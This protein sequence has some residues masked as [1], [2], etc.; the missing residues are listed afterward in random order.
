MEP[1]SPPWMY[2]NLGK[3]HTGWEGRNQEAKPFT[4]GHPEGPWVKS[5]L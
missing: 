5:P 1:L 4:Q 3:A 2:S